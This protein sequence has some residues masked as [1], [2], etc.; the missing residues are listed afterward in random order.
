MKYVTLVTIGFYVLGAALSK[1][2]DAQISDQVATFYQLIR[3]EFVLDYPAK[4]V[5]PYIIDRQSWITIFPSKTVAGSPGEEGEVVRVQVVSENA[6]VGEYFAKTL[7]VIPGRQLVIKWLPPKMSPDGIDTLRGYDVYD[8]EEIDGKTKVIFQ[9]F[10]EHTSRQWSEEDFHLIMK[11][12]GELGH[13]RWRE[14]YIPALRIL[15]QRDKT[16]IDEKVFEQNSDLSYF[17]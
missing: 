14:D 16:N 4:K 9:T 3:I 15:L 6:I 7:R 10:Q 8:L 2:E 1:A 11:A 12:G 5:W 17:K 13:K